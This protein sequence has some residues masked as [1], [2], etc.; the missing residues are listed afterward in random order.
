MKIVDN[1][2]EILNDDNHDTADDGVLDFMYN[3]LKKQGYYKGGKKSK[4]SKGGK[5]SNKKTLKKKNK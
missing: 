1:I 3:K 2:K 4:K 5:K